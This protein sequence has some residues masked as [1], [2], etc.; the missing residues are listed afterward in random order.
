MFSPKCSTGLVNGTLVPQ[1]GPVSGDSAVRFVLEMAAGKDPF[2]TALW[3]AVQGGKEIR[4][5]VS[6][7]DEKKR[8]DTRETFR[9]YAERVQRFL[10][11]TA[12]H[13]IHPADTLVES[14]DLKADHV[15]VDIGIAIFEQGTFYYRTGHH[16][17][18]CALALGIPT[19]PV[20]CYFA[21]ALAVKKIAAREKS[22]NWRDATAKYLDGLHNT[23]GA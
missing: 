23:Q 8:I 14:K 15:D 13:G 22:S 12:V 6:E 21:S 2:D 16:R 11:Y 10:R 17:V 1:I 5:K 9:L 3:H 7:S 19:I 18:A 4:R 20:R